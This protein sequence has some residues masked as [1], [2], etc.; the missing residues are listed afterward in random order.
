MRIGY[1][2]HCGFC[3]GT[4]LLQRDCMV[5][6]FTDAEAEFHHTFNAATQEL[7]NYNNG[8]Y[9]YTKDK[10]WHLKESRLNKIIKE[11]IKKALKESVIKSREF[12][13]KDENVCYGEDEMSFFAA[14]YLRNEFRRFPDIVKAKACAQEMLQREKQQ[15][16]EEMSGL[17]Y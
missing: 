15:R 8:N 4:G 16:A 9:D 1:H 12:L 7:D 14:N 11:S 13:D 6:D 3:F 17:R 10:G 5:R 2:L